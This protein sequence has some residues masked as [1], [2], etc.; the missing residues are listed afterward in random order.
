MQAQLR[1]SDLDAEADNWAC[2]ELE[3]MK[4]RK[5]LSE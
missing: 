1:H 3:S 2:G 4:L 5:V